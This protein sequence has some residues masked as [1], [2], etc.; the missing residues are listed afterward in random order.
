MCVCVREREREREK[1]RKREG[2]KQILRF[3]VGRWVT[4]SLSLTNH[5]QL[6]PRTRAKLH[7]NA[8]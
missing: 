1:E 2:E 3:L 8:S 7:T 4:A 5:M 6:S